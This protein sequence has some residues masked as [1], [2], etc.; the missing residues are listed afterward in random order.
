MTNQFEFIY[1]IGG[2]E[3]RNKKNKTT[4]LI[5]KKDFNLCLVCRRVSVSVRERERER[6]R[7][8][9]RQTETESITARKYLQ[10]S[11]HGLL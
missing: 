5:S 3:R 10:K 1:D 8:T 11:S 2:T 7:Q 9:D 6:E 4:A